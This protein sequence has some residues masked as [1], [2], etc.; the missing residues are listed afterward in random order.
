[1]IFLY[2]NLFMIDIIQHITIFLV[3]V[4]KIQKW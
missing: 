2:E 3:Y 1:M 4:V